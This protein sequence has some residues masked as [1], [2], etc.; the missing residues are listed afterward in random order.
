MP[1]FRP[2]LGP[3]PPNRPDSFP[4]SV[5][6]ADALTPDAGKP[7]PPEGTPASDALAVCWLPAGLGHTGQLAAV[8]HVAETYT[9]DAELL[10]R[11]AGAAVDL[12]TVAQAHR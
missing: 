2:V 8:G 3:V 7:A 1:G 5:P 9:R 4:F 6:P 12:V 10:E 11:A